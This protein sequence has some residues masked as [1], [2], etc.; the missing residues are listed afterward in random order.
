LIDR[1]LRWPDFCNV[2]L[3]SQKRMEASIMKKDSRIVVSALAS[4]ALA[5]A[6]CLFPPA[7]T[8]ANAKRRAHAQD[9]TQ[10]QAV[11]GKIASVGKTSFTLTVKSDHVSTQSPDQNQTPAPTDTM[12]FR[13]D[14]NTTVDGT[15]QVGANADVTYREDSSGNNLAI[16]VRVTS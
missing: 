8:N 10:T 14:S 3:A 11:S 5:S 1:I 16:S 7:A 12:R 4:F 15:L 2:L 6:I 13:I 9:A